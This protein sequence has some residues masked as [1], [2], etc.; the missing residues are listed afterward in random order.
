M[1]VID[2]IFNKNKKAQM[3]RTDGYFKMLNS[4]TPIFST[5]EGGVYEQELTRSAIHAFAT[6]CSKLMAECTDESLQC[7]LRNKPN[8]FM[9]GS[10]FLYRVA[11]ILSITNTCYIVPIEDKYGYIVGYYPI[12]PNLTEVLDVGGEP[13]LKYTFSNGEKACV[14]F[15]KVGVLTNFQYKNDFKGESNGVLKST[16]N[17]IDAQNQGIVEGIKNGSNIRFM[18]KL[19]N[20]MK[21][22]DLKSKQKEFA[23]TNLNSNDTGV[24]IFG[25]EYGDV[26]QVDNKNFIV[27]ADQMKLIQENVF[28]YFGCNLD[29]LQNKYSEETLNAYYEGKIEPFATQLSNALTNMTYSFNDQVKGKKIFYSDNRMQYTS[30]NTKV[31]LTQQLLDRG[32]LSRNE[33]R[34]IL[35]LSPVEGGDEF[36]IRGEYISADTLKEKQ[37]VEVLNNADKE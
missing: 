25:T 14:E 21:A 13:Y 37:K 23:E 4:Y 22:D 2:K 5:F 34:E 17:L 11:T 36:V 18:A 15:S 26:K 1:G 6:H 27:D 3:I 30:I 16:M 32:V 10:Q 20:F 33:A 19:N 31:T 28:N 12:V 8:Y 9:S 35:N 7:I 24:L 29:I